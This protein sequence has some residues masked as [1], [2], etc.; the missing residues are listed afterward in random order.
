M[1]TDPQLWMRSRAG[2]AEAFGELVSRHQA[3]VGSVA[4]SRCGDLS[5]SEEIAQETF[6]AAWRQRD[7]LEDP[8]RLRPWLAGIARNLASGH[9]RR[10]RRRGGG[11]AFGPEGVGDEPA[12]PEEDP[13]EVTISREEGELLWRTLEALPANYREPLVLF[14][15]GGR[16]VSEVALDLGLTEETARQRLS[17]GRALLREE[18]AGV[19]ERTLA[20]GRPSALFTAAVL[21]SLPLLPSPSAEASP[22]APSGAGA[23]TGIA[24][25]AGKG[26]TAFAKAGV[27]GWG[28]GAVV[29]PAI[30]LV[31]GSTSIALLAATARSRKERRCLAGH[32]WAMVAFSALMSAGLAMVLGQAG[33]T[34]ATNVWGVL[35]IVALW[36]G[37]LLLGIL[38]MNARMHRVLVRLRK[39]SGTGALV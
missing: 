1:E 5:R 37:I 30:G 3:L 4:F 13:A 23:G 17:R 36:F 27:P 29:G 12:S 16:S 25:L 8:S 10:E 22:V 28:I 2:D 32:G 35:G 33:R 9:V 38:A 26:V 7:S 21:A 11:S 20:R 18:L 34:Y 6:L 15:R 31:V 14:Y 39:Q 19:L 24:G